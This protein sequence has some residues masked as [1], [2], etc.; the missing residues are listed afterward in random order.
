MKNIALTIILASL[1]LICYSQDFEVAPVKLNY[2]CEPGEIQTKTLTIR[3]HDNKRQQFS[4]TVVA[5]KFDSSDAKTT[6][7]K[8]CKDWTTINP[9]LFDIN[10]NENIEVKVIMQVPPGEF[11][12]RGALIQVNATEEQNSFNADKQIVKSAIRVSPRI[13]VKVLQSPKSNNNFKGSVS[14][15][16]EI[17]QPNDSIRLFEVKISNTGDK[18]IDAKIYLVASSLET[19]KEY[20]EQPI[21]RSLFPGTSEKISIPL[22]KNLPAGMYS[23]AAILDYSNNSALEAAQLEIEVK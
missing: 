16:K 14:N 5:I 22:P 23:L 18:L 20:K 11:N 7:N 3:N 13:S 4:L 9:P 8:S 19:A 21:T 17:T 2:D 10:P 15:L 12:T 1:S 6:Q